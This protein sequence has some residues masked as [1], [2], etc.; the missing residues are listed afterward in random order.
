MTLGLGIDTGGTYT[1]AVIY[2]FDTQEILFSSKALTTKEDLSIGIDHVL[3]GISI[4]ILK[5][6]D[7]VSLSTTL[8]T[9][10]CVEERGGRGKIIFIGADKEIIKSKGESYGLPHSSEIFFLDGEVSYKGE[11]IKEPDWKLFLE[12]SKEWIKD[13]DAVAIVQQLGIRNAETEIKAKE[14]I[15][16]EYKLN[17]VCGHELYSDLNYIK[18]G[19]STLLNAKLIPIIGDFLLSIERCLKKRDI[20]V[21]VVILRSDG[22]L[23]SESFTRVRPVETLL[24]G[25]A[26]SVMGGIKLTEEKNSIIVDMGGTTTDM[27]LVKDSLPVK[28][29]DGVTV[30]KWQTFVKSIYINTF[31]LGGDSRVNINKD[32]RLQLYPNRIMPLSVAAIKWPQIIDKLNK[33]KK[34]NIVKSEPLHEFFYLVKDISNSQSYSKEELLF[35]EALKE[36]PLIYSEAIAKIQSRM[37]I[38]KLSRLENEGIIMR[39]GV[40]PTDAMHIKGDFNGFN[41]EAAKLGVSYLCDQHNRLKHDFT[42]EEWTVEGLCVQIYD[43]VKE[44]LYLNIM[45]FLLED[46]YTSYKKDGIDENLEQ[47]IRDSWKATSKEESFMNIG[48][49]ISSGSIVGVGAPTHIFLPDV[50]KALGCDYVVPEFAGVANALGAIVGNVRVENKVEIKPNED[51]GF[52]IYGKTSN[53]LADNLQDAIEIATEEAKKEAIAEATRRGAVGDISV[54]VAINENASALIE[55]FGEFVSTTVIATAVGNICL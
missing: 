46:K 45:K 5:Q 20:N 40:T 54:T 24:C 36:G 27:A 12:E 19:S 28:V 15:E 50:A 43:L 33:L 10:A 48:F 26:A 8:A 2:D 41:T 6:V 4:E 18:R 14:L 35:C 34:T 29:S 44:T 42:T 1:D 55:L 52:I 25:P 38:Y 3:D 30:G 11:I 7:I 49:S 39:C 37:G 13:A 17:T 16:K 9:N 32:K 21:P 23:M 47:L 31:G 51:E 22:S 53:L